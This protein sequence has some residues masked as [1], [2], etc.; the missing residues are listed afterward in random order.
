M[1]T[2]K[3]T[4]VNERKKAAPKKK[5]RQSSPL[6]KFLKWTFLTLVFA[7][8]VGAMGSAWFMY[9]NIQEVE[10]LVEHIDE[11]IKEYNSKPSRIYS[12]HGKLLY[13]IRPIYRDPVA[14]SD[15]PEYVKYA[16]LAAED[17]RFYE[18]HG[19]DYMGLARATVHL[20]SKG[21]VDGG[22]S[23]ITMQLAKKL[24]SASQ[25]TF[26]RKIQDISIA[27]NLEKKYTKDQI[28]ELYINQIYYGEQAYGLNAAAEIYF[29][30]EAKDLDLAEAAMIARCI[31]LPSSQN[32]V[33][34]YQISDFNKKVVLNTMLEQGWITQGEYDK[35][36][37]EKP[38]VRG[39]ARQK[40]SKIYAAPY[41][42]AAVKRD[43]DQLGINISEGGYTITT[44]LDSDLQE[45]AEKSTER[46]IRNNDEANVGAFICMDSE[47]RILADV[48]GRD[49]SKNQ[50]SYT[51]QSPLQPGSSF[52]SFVY[53]EALKEGVLND[54]DSEISNEM[55]KWPLGNGRYYNPRNHGGYGGSVSLWSA[56]VNSI[57]VPAVHTM[58]NIGPKRA[59]DL[60]TE[61]FGFD[62]K[63]QPYPASAL[64]ASEVKPIEMLEA[65]SVFALDGRRV[66]PYRI[67]EILGPEGNIVYQGKM[68]YVTTR[69]GPSICATMDKLMRGVVTSG[70]GTQAGECPDARGK[71]G[72]TNDGKSLWFCGYSKGVIGIAVVANQ[73]YDR[74]HHR[75][76]LRPMNQYGGS[77]AAPIWAQAMIPT[78]AKYGS[79]VKPDFSKHSESDEMKHKPKPEVPAATD[80]NNAPADNPDDQNRVTIDGGPG[81]PA[82]GDGPPADGGD[83]VPTDPKN[84]PAS[85]PGTGDV[86][87]T[88]TNGTNGPKP[89]DDSKTKKPSDSDYVEVEVCADSGMLAT[90]YCPETINRR[91]L[92]SKRP[93]KKCTIHHAP[94]EGGG[95]K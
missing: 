11:K 54:E 76:L 43:L 8:C 23:T 32:P 71:T 49:F 2:A 17:K 18:H 4:V 91:F 10:P 80:A 9:K 33:R 15:L 73:T 46:E 45:S 7:G 90:R 65:Y 29:G 64:G 79:D 83:A 78:I 26:R 50:Y 48:G 22:G 84:D 3:R 55:V 21:E 70:T 62:S 6:V 16:I 82:T 88:K 94:D 56:F 14:L 86:P 75:W 5:K 77:T 28:L 20:A 89:P 39:F 31:R 30:K 41:F 85:N 19:V 92:K 12:A 36:K 47:G 58:I 34:N 59:A 35:A 95:M 72:T 81:A 61:D 42:V 57:N 66:K 44:T 51:T 37:A 24:F 52:K 13:E 87:P 27:F 74:K 68:E 93:R 1:A 38:K 40:F 63:I 69:I 53:S 60:I 67:K 25:V